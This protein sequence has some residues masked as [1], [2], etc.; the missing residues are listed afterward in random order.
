M[1]N[2]INCIILCGGLGTRL[3]SVVHD[4]PKSMALI[5]GRPF[6]EYLF[7]KILETNIK[8]VVLSTGYMHDKIESYFGN[9]FKDIKIIYS[10]EF[11]QLGTGGA[12]LKALNYSKKLKSL[13]IN[14]DTYVEIDL[15]KVIS[16]TINPNKN[17]MVAQY[18]KDCSRYHKITIHKNSQIYLNKKNK[19]IP[20]YINGG[21]YILNNSLKNEFKN[22]S[23]SFEN[24][25]LVGRDLN[26]KFQIIKNN[27]LFIDIGIPE[28][29]KKAKEILNF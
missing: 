29:L 13:V 22:Q 19:N 1:H 16:K 21:I 28:D 5:N 15:N 14:G 12:I 25:F 7:N 6:L 8:E 2:N 9:N 27:G 24:D 11:E 3:R 18:I 17:L 20:G 26:T 23:F 4:R 10:R